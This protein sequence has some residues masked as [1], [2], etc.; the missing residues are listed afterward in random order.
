MNNLENLIILYGSQTGNSQDLSERIWRK[1]K[2][3]KLTAHLR[4]FDRFDLTKLNNDKVK[5]L[6]VCSTTGQGDVPDNMTKFWRKIMKKNIPNDS[7]QNV[8]FCIIGLGDSSYEKYNFIAK[9]LYKRFIQLGATPLLDLCLCDDQQNDG[10]EGAYSKW[11]KNF[12]AAMNVNTNNLITI[13]K[14]ISKYRVEFLNENDQSEGKETEAESYPA[15]SVKPF[16]A[17][18][19]KNDRVT[20]KDHFQDTRLIEFDCSN[21]T[22]IKYEPGD[23]LLLKPCNVPSNVEKFLNIFS[24]LNLNLDQKIRI[25]PNYENEI[26]NDLEISEEFIKSVGD[27]IEKYLDMN[28]VPRMSFFEMFANLAQD[29]M[30]KEKLEEFLTPEGLEDLYNYCYRPK[31]NIIEIFHDFPK[32]SKL[33]NSLEILLDLVPS[34]KP[35]SFSIASCPSVNKDRLQIL[36]AGIVFTKKFNF[37]YSGFSM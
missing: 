8:E 25:V 23:V 10:I 9:K 1:A 11:I 20:H 36:V 32:T 6:C 2:Y 4:S 13:D 27:L 17:Q 37:H 19:S 15:S 12:W 18:L 26:E 5:L 31:R 3:L 16:Y 35:R 21:T 30:E 28:S 7:L 34:I 24:H 22:R 14:T 33:V 29:K